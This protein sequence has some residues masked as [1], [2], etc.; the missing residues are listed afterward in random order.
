MELL[1]LLSLAW[2]LVMR[3]GSWWKELPWACSVV[4]W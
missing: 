1:Q 3:V 4:V 2:L